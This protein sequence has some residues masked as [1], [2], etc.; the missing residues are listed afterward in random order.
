MPGG[1]ATRAAVS[2]RLVGA[3]AVGIALEDG[4]SEAGL[5]VAVVAALPC[6]ASLLLCLAPV[7]VALAVLGVLR[8][9][10]G[11]ADAPALGLGHCCL[12]LVPCRPTTG[13]SDETC[14]RGRGVRRAELG[15]LLG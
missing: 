8:T 14:V 5:V 12:L 10:G 13:G 11:G 1:L 15:R 6:A 2:V 7:L 4:A 3:H 9:A